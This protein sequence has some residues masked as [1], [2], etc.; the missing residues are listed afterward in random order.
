MADRDVTPDPSSSEGA[1][2]A[3]DLLEKCHTL[4]AEYIFSN[5]KLNLDV[6]VLTTSRLQEFKTFIEE[7]NKEKIVD[8][9]HFQSSV[10]SELKSLE[11]VGHFE[12]EIEFLSI[13]FSS[14]VPA[15]SRRF[16]RRANNTYSPLFQSTLL[17]RRVG[18]RKV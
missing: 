8:I 3:E 2:V 1:I 14:L 13:A 7:R 11:K 5:C 17:C 12:S 4:L 9:R 15:F 10:R 16:Y 6:L 18:R